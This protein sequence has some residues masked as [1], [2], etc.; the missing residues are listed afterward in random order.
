M[1]LIAAPGRWDP[2]L[3]RIFA[4]QP[5]RVRGHVEHTMLAK[6][7]G[8]EVLMVIGHHPDAGLGLLVRGQAVV[9]VATQAKVQRPRALGDRVLQIQR[10]LFHV[11]VPAKRKQPTSARQIDRQQRG[12]RRIQ[13]HAEPGRRPT[14]GR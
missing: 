8:G 11:R 14:H 12:A 3:C 5:D 13:R 2:E 7:Y 10:K 6:T 1:T 4:L 9:Q